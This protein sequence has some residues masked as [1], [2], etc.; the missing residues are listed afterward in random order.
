MIGRSELDASTPATGDWPG[1]GQRYSSLAS[2]RLSW[3][4]I[5]LATNGCIAFA[6]L[7]GGGD[8][9]NISDKWCVLS[10]NQIPV[11]K[12]QQHVRRHREMPLLAAKRWTVLTVLAHDGRGIRKNHGQ[13]FGKAV[14]PGAASLG[15]RLLAQRG[16][17]AAISARLADMNRPPATYRDSITSHAK[18]PNENTP[19]KT[20]SLTPAETRVLTLLTTYQTLADIG[21]ELGISR[22]T[23]KTHV[24]N[25]YKKLGATR[26]AEAVKLAES[27]SLLPGVV[28]LSGRKPEKLDRLSSE[29][30]RVRR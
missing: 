14:T 2:L 6:P 20:V 10:R 19:R 1:E 21:C 16:P 13:P 17:G 18:P 3:W 23:V 12:A 5:T 28:L 25:I 30:G 7:P 29:R 9:A 24:Q 27:A 11:P 8:H 4:S 22:P 26:R 15:A